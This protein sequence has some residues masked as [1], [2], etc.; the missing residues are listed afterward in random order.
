ML[1]AVTCFLGAISLA[2]GCLSARVVQDAYYFQA[3]LVQLQRSQSQ[4]V[5]GL[6]EG[7]VLQYAIDREF[8]V[9]A[10]RFLVVNVGSPLEPRPAD[11][12]EALTAL[13]SDSR[14]WFVAHVYFSNAGRL[15]L[16]PTD[17]FV[18]RVRSSENSDTLA[19]APPKGLRF[20]RSVQGTEDQFVLRLAA[21]NTENPVDA[22]RRLFEE[23]RFLWVEPNF[24]EER[25]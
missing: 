13:R 24:V 12:L 9:S 10:R 19:T 20:A 5:V 11:V 18:V 7:A 25:R 23:G 14:V 15:R 4:L 8:V 3:Q 1:T 22:A 2:F 17:E 6:H 16:F 21:P